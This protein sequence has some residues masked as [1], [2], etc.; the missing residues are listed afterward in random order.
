MQK[1]GSAASTTAARQ[2]SAAKQSDEAW[3]PIWSW[4]SWLR[5]IFCNKMSSQESN[6]P[7][8]TESSKEMLEV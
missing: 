5:V 4:E 8:R 3:V 1:H 7:C 2:L 6:I